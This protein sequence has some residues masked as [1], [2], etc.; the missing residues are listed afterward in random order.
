MNQ[1]TMRDL[2]TIFN[3]SLPPNLIQKLKEHLDT[4][5]NVNQASLSLLTAKNDIGEMMSHF[6]AFHNLRPRPKKPILFAGGIEKNN[7]KPFPIVRIDKSNHALKS[8]VGFTFRYRKN[9]KSNNVCVKLTEKTI[10]A[11]PSLFQ[12]Q[13]QWFSTR[14]GEK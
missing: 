13:L 11:L 1:L 7:G 12:A 9:Q 8:V 6:S 2:H 14:Y 10:G 3:N 5:W 4:F